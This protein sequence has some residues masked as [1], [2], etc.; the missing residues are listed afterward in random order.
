VLTQADAIQKIK[1][2]GK[3]RK[4]VFISLLDITPD[5][6]KTDIATDVRKGLRKKDK[7][8]WNGIKGKV[9]EDLKSKG[10]LLCPV[11]QYSEFWMYPDAILEARTESFRY[12]LKEAYKQLFPF[13]AYA[14]NK[15]TSEGVMTHHLYYGENE[16]LL[17]HFLEY[18]ADRI[19]GIPLLRTIESEVG[20]MART[21]ASLSKPSPSKR[22]DVVVRTLA[23]SN[24]S[25]RNNRDKGVF[26]KV[27]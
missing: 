23:K 3:Q 12:D 1:E 15:R 25:V 9:Q 24:L 11:G 7:I 18:E 14:N 5:E 21:A 22:S 8:L 16:R 2:I 17:V 6:N 20:S 10:E 4:S 27:P 26:E 19:R 13:K